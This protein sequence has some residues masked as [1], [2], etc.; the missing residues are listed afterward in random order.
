MAILLRFF[1]LGSGSNRGGPGIV[2]TMVLDKAGEVIEVAPNNPQVPFFRA[3]DMMEELEPRVVPDAEEI[4]PE[5]VL[6]LEDKRQRLMDAITENLQDPGTSM[7]K[8]R[9]IAGVSTI[10][11]LKKPALVEKILKDLKAGDE[12][13]IARYKLA[14][15]PAGQEPEAEEKKEEASD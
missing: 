3:S 14:F 13:A 5:P 12:E 11:R 1:T 9:Q 2:G 6:S 15:L 10:S 7:A 8:L 4:P